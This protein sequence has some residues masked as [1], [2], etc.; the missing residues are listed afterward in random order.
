MGF[1]S[2]DP[3]RKP[4]QHADT[5]RGPAG[6]AE[7]LLGRYR[8]ARRL[9]AGGFGTV[10]LAHDE[11]LNRPVALKRIPLDDG[12]PERAEREAQAAARPEARRGRGVRVVRV[13]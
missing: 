7:L 10:W 13:G 6:S 3:N 2:R 11:R 1:P 5:L 8:L 12:D 4:V 9:G